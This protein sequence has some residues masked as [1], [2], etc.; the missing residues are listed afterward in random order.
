VLNIYN[1]VLITDVN[2]V[3]IDLP[4]KSFKLIYNGKAKKYI[5]KLTCALCPELLNRDK[6]LYSNLGVSKFYVF[7]S[8]FDN[9]ELIL[10][11]TAYP[12][13][14]ITKIMEYSVSPNEADVFL[15]IEVEL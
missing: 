3:Q 10:D 7:S 14:G 4:I 1:N 9:K 6:I 2:D 13:K 5:I 11:L 15:Y 8:G 12:Q